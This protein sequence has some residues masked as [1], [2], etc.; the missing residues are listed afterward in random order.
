MMVGVEPLLR[1]SGLHVSFETSRG[2]IRAVDGVDLEV[3]TGEVLGLVGESG[4]GKS[5]TLR[6]ITRT[7]IRT[8]V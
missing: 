4:S 7:C 8:H 5:V 1:V 6:S 2:S 3:R